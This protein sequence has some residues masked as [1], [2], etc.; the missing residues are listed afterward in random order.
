MGRTFDVKAELKFVWVLALVR[1]SVLAFLYISISCGF[2][3]ATPTIAKK[4]VSNGREIR[5]MHATGLK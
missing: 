5:S 1:P 4:G 2:K 3:A